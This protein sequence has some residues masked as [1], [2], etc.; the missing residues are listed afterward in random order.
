MN[1]NTKI[2]TQT[3]YRIAVSS[4]YF[5]QGL[6]FATWACRIPDVKVALQ[7]S[8]AELG[9][10][11]F[12]VPVG[13]LTTMAL[14][15]YLVNRFG[16]RRIL[17]LAA[18]LYPATLLLLGLAHTIPMLCVGL[19][20]FGI[21][22]NLSNISV[23]TQGV[24]V[25]RLYGRSIMAS[26]HGLWSLAGFVGG[27]IGTW[28]VGYN[29]EPLT[30][31]IFVC[32]LCYGLLLV[33]R[34]SLLPRDMAPEK[35][36]EKRA[37]SMPDKYILLLGL[38]AFANMACEGTMYDW[39]S[40]YFEQ[41]IDPPKELVRLGYI[42]CMGSMTCGRFFADKLIT[43]FGFVNVIRFS[44]LIISGGLL[45]AVLFPNLTVATVGFLLVG[46][47]ISSTIPICYSLAGKS[48]TMAPGVAL[49]MV[50][51]IG[52]LGFL[53]GPPVIGLIAQVL[54]LRWSFA[55]IACI[56]VVTTLLAPMLKNQK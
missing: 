30:H 10:V 55:L 5:I 25:E 28:M 29:F 52:F 35:K 4:F 15:G 21:A 19:F 2:R 23:N 13:Q 49:A 20:C 44:G 46:F 7:M 34:N 3:L 32:F 33:M 27:L 50:S 9:G 56:G 14:A 38:I 1:F 37:F 18:I 51:T 6:V 39:S 22:S 40:V 43:R 31:F 41:I 36:S 53:L 26:F 17:T 12:T 8:D 45:I 54:S 24:G 48:K 11:L 47:G 16:S 42:A